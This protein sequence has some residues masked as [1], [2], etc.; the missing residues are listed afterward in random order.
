MIELAR[1]VN[2]T[3]FTKPSMRGTLLGRSVAS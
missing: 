1:P 2:V 3:A